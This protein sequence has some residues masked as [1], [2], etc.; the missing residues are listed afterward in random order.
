M[1][2][3]RINVLSFFR[4]ITN[5]VSGSGVPFTVTIKSKLWPCQFSLAQGPKISVFFSFVHAGLY[6]LCAAL[7]CSFRLT[8][9]IKTL[10]L[11]QIY[12]NLQ[13]KRSYDYC[14]RSS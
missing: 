2:S 9:T 13:Q 7:K 12:V 14:Y 6:S 10:K 5:P 11:L 3:E 1:T 4:S 8:C